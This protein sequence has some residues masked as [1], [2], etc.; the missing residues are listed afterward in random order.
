MK[1]GAVFAELIAKTQDF[2][3][4][5]NRAGNTLDQFGLRSRKLE[6]QLRN[7]ERQK[8]TVNKRLDELT[9]KGK[10]TSTS[11]Q[12]LSN[13]AAN[14]TDR[15]NTQ[16]VAISQNSARM[17]QVLDTA[18]RLPNP[19]DVAGKA[20]TKLGSLGVNAMGSLFNSIKRVGEV[21]LGNILANGFSTATN[22]IT[23]FAKSAFG[24]TTSLQDTRGGFEAMLGS[25]EEAQKVLIGLSDYNKKTPFQLPEL[26]EQTA[27]LIAAQVATKD[28]IPTLDMLGKISRGNSRRLGLVTL[29]YTQVRDATRLTGAELRQFTEN[30]V[31]LLDL[32]AK[33]SNKTMGQIREDISNQAISFEMVDKALKSTVQEGGIFYN[34]FERQSGNFSF[35]SSNILDEIGI[36]GRSI[37]GITETGDIV[38]GG[39][40][41]QISIQAQNLLGFIKENKQSIQDFGLALGGITLDII[42]KLPKLFQDV[43]DAIILTQTALNDLSNWYN[44]NSSW[45]LTLGIV[46]GSLAT[47]FTLAYGAVALFN[48]IMILATT[49]AGA[50][51]VVMAVITSPIFLIGLAIGALIAVG[52]LLYQNWE[53]ITQKGKEFWNWL[54]SSILGGTMKA[55]NIFVD[56][57]KDLF[58]KWM[59][60]FDFI[61][62]I[63]VFKIGVNIIEGLING[64]KSMISNLN[65]MVSGVANG[66]ADGFK[67]ALGIQSPSKVFEMFGKYTAQGYQQGVEGQTVQT[68]QATA[69]MASSA[70]AGAVSVDQSNAININGSQNPN[71][72]MQEVKKFLATQNNLAFNGVL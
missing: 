34:Y 32:L 24:A 72:I 69:G 48:G 42:N 21:A 54:T 31:P 61:R 10:T 11:F 71:L 35:V 49:I 57:N 39:I 20:F 52:V 51:G 67:K 62:N 64:I 15:I 36:V 56:F 17:Q 70:T 47:G 16:N 27:N 6:D 65:N 3:S 55:I 22:A 9:Q 4:Q 33:Q 66:I 40:F 18:N 63:D 60:I 29:A 46:I 28:I 5:M 58:Q 26:Q 43:K 12:T 23:N 45:I 7:L 8:Q 41:E 68:A 37:M 30:G 50:F 13:R 25:A 19:L 59:D 38:K 53:T 2:T 1:V 14:L 44:A